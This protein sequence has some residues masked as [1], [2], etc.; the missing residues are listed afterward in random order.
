MKLL[1]MRAIIKD[2][3]FQNYSIGIFTS[4]DGS[5]YLQAKYMD[6]DIVT[7]REEVQT[8]R[9]W[10]LSEH[11]TKSELVQT[12]FKCCLTSM[13]HRTRESF[14]YKGKRIFGPHFDVELLVLLCADNGFD[15]REAP[16]P[17]L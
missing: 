16:I 10:I 3:E 7:G 12:A 15:V 9:K 14:K 8:T 6:A 17:A 2:V 1:E 11:M 4:I 5:L 13:E